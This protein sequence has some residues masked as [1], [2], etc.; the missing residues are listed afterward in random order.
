VTYLRNKIKFEIWIFVAEVTRLPY[1]CSR[2][3]ENDSYD[4]LLF[5][6]MIFMLI[7]DSYVFILC[8]S[9]AFITNGLPCY[10]DD[11]SHCK[12]ISVCCQ[13]P[14]VIMESPGCP[15]PV[16]ARGSTV[17]NWTPSLLLVPG[18]TS[19]QQIHPLRYWAVSMSK[20]GSIKSWSQPLRTSVTPWRGIKWDLNAYSRGKDGKHVTACARAKW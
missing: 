1:R 8:T 9:I 3:W 13:G 16:R 14:V 15:G 6:S 4:L 17:S 11:Y 18:V 2:Y 7:Y 12:S 5:Y 10:L 19:R 20:I